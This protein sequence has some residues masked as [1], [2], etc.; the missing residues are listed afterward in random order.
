MRDTKD[1]ESRVESAIVHA[2]TEGKSRVYIPY[3]FTNCDDIVILKFYEETPYPILRLY[4]ANP[5]PEG[6]LVTKTAIPY[7]LMATLKNAGFNTENLQNSQ[8]IKISWNW[9]GNREPEET[10]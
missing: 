1:V 10:A 7:L 3:D 5:Y 6:D 2:A 9:R 8:R 4:E